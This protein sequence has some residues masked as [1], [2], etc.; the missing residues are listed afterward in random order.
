MPN[1]CLRSAPISFSSC[2]LSTNTLFNSI[3]AFNLACL[4]RAVC[5]AISASIS[6]CDALVLSRVWISLNFASSNES[7]ACSSFV[8]TLFASA[9]SFAAWIW[10]SLIFNSCLSK[11]SC[12][13]IAIFSRFAAA[14]TIKLFFKTALFAFTLSLIDFNCD[15]WVI[16]MACAIA[17]C[18]AAIGISFAAISAKFSWAFIISFRVFSISALILNLSTRLACLSFTCCWANLVCK[19]VS[20]EDA[21]TTSTPA[22]R[23]IF[24]PNAPIASPINLLAST[25]ASSASFWI[26]NIL[27][28]APSNSWTRASYW[29]DSAVFLINLPAAFSASLKFVTSASVEPLK[30][31]NAVSVLNKADSISAPIDSALSPANIALV[32]KSSTLIPSSFC[33]TFAAV[34]DC[35]SNLDKPWAY[36]LAL[37]NAFRFLASTFLFSLSWACS[38][39]APLPPTCLASPK[40][41][42]ET[43]S[44]AASNF[45]WV[46]VASSAILL[47][48]PPKIL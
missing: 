7:A 34:S 31:F 18:L 29:V 3:S 43:P 11:S 5:F 4:S 23:V 33:I 8:K 16:S 38:A 48:N 47:T 22:S 25:P 28:V 14:A 2:I 35:S 15:F 20:W 19:S 37:L 17:S 46:V 30:P 40:T 45:C 26:L 12:L 32:M 6:A 10:P 39:P 27:F 1:S 44:L 24:L 36:A 21:L 41:K 42:S 9:L 13:S